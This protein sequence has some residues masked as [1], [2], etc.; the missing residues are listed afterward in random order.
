[1]KEANQAGEEDGLDAVT[2][3]GQVWRKRIPT[4]IK[5]DARQGARTKPS[6][7]KGDLCLNN[8]GEL[9]SFLTPDDWWEIQLRHTNPKL[10]ATDK[11]N[12]KLTVGE[13][14]RWWGY[15]LALSINPGTPIERAWALTCE[16]GS[17]LPPMNMHGEAR[18]DHK[19][20]EEDPLG[21]Q[22]RTMR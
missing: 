10:L 7:N 9:F 18:H 13:L 16:P 4:Y 2:A 22:L 14:K 3:D 12:A 6:L 8:I 21:A 15:A 17:V 1:V 19:T 5:E 11:E 20:L